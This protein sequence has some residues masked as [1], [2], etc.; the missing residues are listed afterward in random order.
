[1]RILESEIDVGCKGFGREC[2]SDSDCCS[3]MSCH[4]ALFKHICLPGAY[5]GK[6][7]K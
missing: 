7:K 4:N 2:N 5:N 6:L 3:P 1:M